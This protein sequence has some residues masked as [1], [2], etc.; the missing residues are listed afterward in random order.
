MKITTILIFMIAIYEKQMVGSKYE[1]GR[2]ERN[3]LKK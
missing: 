2:L 1:D 3:R